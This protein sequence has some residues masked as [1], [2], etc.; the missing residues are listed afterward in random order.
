M[1]HSDKNMGK[2]KCS[3]KLFEGKKKAP[4]IIL[5]CFNK[6]HLNTKLLL[7]SNVLPAGTITVK[8]KMQKC[9]K[10]SRGEFVL[11]VDYS[12]KSGTH[13]QNNLP[14]CYVFFIFSSVIIYY[15]QKN[16][17]IYLVVLPDSFF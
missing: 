5:F 7:Q 4:W 16:G 11:N 8:I 9:V 15:L 3:N 10:I 12:Y 13:I 2:I 1:F 6:N 17:F 14:H